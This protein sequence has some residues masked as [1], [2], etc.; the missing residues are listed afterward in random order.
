MN[1]LPKDCIN[2]V[3]NVEN[4]LFSVL[5]KAPKTPKSPYL[6]RER[7]IEQKTLIRESR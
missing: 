3:D 5:K 4:S 1:K 2:A 6:S 7:N